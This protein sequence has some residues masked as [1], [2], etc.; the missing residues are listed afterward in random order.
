[1]IRIATLLP[2]FLCVSSL[3]ADQDLV[4][5]SSADSLMEAGHYKRAR[6]VVAARLRANPKDSY[7]LFLDSKIKQSFGDFPGAIA[8]AERAVALEPHNANYHAQ[9]AEVYAFSADQSSWLRGMNL[10]HLMKRE[11]AA[12][13]AI[14]PKH[15][16]TLLVS[17]MFCLRAPKFVGGDKRRARAIAGEIVQSDPNWGYLAEARLL[18]NSGDDA[19]LEALLKQAVE[20]NPAHYRAVYELA[21]FYCCAA[22]HK[23]PATAE[24]TSRKAMQIDPGRVGA[25]DLI[26]RVYAATRRWAEL[27][28][29]L[30][31]SEKAV[32]DDFAPFYQAANILIQDGND[33]PRATAYLRKYLSQEPEGREPTRAQAQSLLGIASGK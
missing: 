16:D 30:G 5:A 28:A 27:D 33:R 11:I 6:A 32:P 15:T 26:A 14:A 13:L 8:S 23:N 2:V 1:M 25:F 29:I 9:L 17:M 4:K 12:S 3:L 22:I 21:R 7:A 19:H 20:V 24:S 10:V 31:Q 18:E